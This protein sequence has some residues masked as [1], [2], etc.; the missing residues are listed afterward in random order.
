MSQASEN[1]YSLSVVKNNGQSES[2]SKYKGQVA[3]VVNTASKCG[4][5]PQYKEL[6][7]VYEKF[8]GRGFEVL[9]FPSNDFGAQEPGS[10]SEIKTF[11]EIN[12]GVKFPLFKKDMV[13]GDAKQIAFKYLTEKGPT[14][15][16]GEIKWNFTKFLINKKGDVVARFESKEKPDSPEVVAQIEKLLNEK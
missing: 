15:T 2:L 9:G 6:Q 10:D 8:H 13:K 3:L 5:T 14:N 11:C 16:H 4:Y 7:A 12:Y 1:F